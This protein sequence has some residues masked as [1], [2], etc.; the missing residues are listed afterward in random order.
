[1]TQNT[2]STIVK[3]SLH[4]QLVADGEPKPSVS[5]FGSHARQEAELQSLYVFFLQG[6]HR[7]SCAARQGEQSTVGCGLGGTEGGMQH[8][9]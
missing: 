8:E 5:E 1:M 2:C 6:A 4:L 3:H 7:A 9:N